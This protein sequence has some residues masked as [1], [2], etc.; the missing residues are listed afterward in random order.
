MPS[1]SK[2]ENS[3][4]LTISVNETASIL[5]SKLLASVGDKLLE[6]VV[7]IPT[8]RALAN[9]FLRLPKEAYRLSLRERGFN[10]L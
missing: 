5:S 4:R 3:A 8:I 2:L 7:F 10:D 6:K 9:T 1:K